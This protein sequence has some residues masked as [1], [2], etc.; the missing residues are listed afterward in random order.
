M[1]ALARIT[2]LWRGQAWRM[3]LGLQI[4]LLALAS[5][6]ALMA[7]SGGAISVAVLAR[8]QSSPPAN[9]THAA[10]LG[11]GTAAPLLL[12]RGLGPARVVLRYLERLTTHSATFRALAGLRVWFF[13]RLAANSAGGLG[14]RDGGDL[15]ARL[16]GDIDRLDGVYLRLLLPLCAMLL[17][18]PAICLLT[19]RLDLP[20]EIA[21]ALLLLLAALLLP[22]AAY[23]ISRAHG[24]KQ[25][26]A[27]AAL[28]IAA[29]DTMT[30]LRE[31]AAFG[32][33][34]RVTA[35]ITTAQTE[36]FAAER[37][38]AR[39]AAF[40]QA[41]SLLCAQGAMLAL[42]C[43][44]GVP[45][46]A[47]ITAVF[48][49]AGSFEMLLA[50]PRA[51]LAAGQAAAAAARVLAAADEPP[52]CPEPAT[53]A[54]LPES[55]CLRFEDVHFGWAADRP[56]VLRGL[57]LEVAP[58]A[59]IA[60]LGPS[61]AG[62]STLAALALRVAA[63]QAGRITLGGTDLAD[64]S[65]DAVRGTIA[66]LGQHSHL[67]ADT[68]RNNLTLARP[69]ATDAEL[70]QA[71]ERAGIAEVVAGLP[72]K[73]DAYLDEGG[74]SLSGGQGRRIALA[75]ALLASRP[76]L[77]L[78][79]PCAG[80]DAQ[81]ERAFLQTLFAQTRGQ[82]VILITHRLTGAEKLDRIWRLSEGRAVAALA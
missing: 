54:P 70:W 55:H 25:A 27:A 39:R 41:A 16:V 21:V 65:S 31:V 72:G 13:G 24:P 46:A 62:K 4:S 59:R 28:Q 49:L 82:S 61:G 18:L 50:M 47:R 20:T 42:L 57:T 11:L 12:L 8:A 51:G 63:P 14:M 37:A 33:Q 69:G 38:L 19:L 3:A 22:A 80:L 32:A 76:L 15:L 73:L 64:L 43:A 40:A 6:L 7:A 56:S 5:G 29:L 44:A 9:A 30:G 77:I 81:T 53:P 35:R 10:L 45:A 23:A 1:N 79:E 60:I 58:G 75:R 17:V 48:V 68:I 67:F 26:R 66:W 52:A 36:L 2:W 78:D 34:A 74:T 71:L